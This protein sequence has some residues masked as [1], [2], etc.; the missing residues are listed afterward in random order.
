ME[1]RFVRTLILF[2]VLTLVFGVL[3][4][5]FPSI[6][7]QPKWRRGVWLDTFYWFFTQLVT[8][9]ISLGAIALAAVP[10]YLLLGRITIQNGTLSLDVN[11]ILAGYGA[12]SYLPLWV[13]GLIM[14]VVGDLIGYWT[15]RWH[16]SRQLWSIHAIHHSSEM[17]DWLTAM[18]LHPLNDIISRVCQATP[19]LLLGFSPMAVDVYVVLLTSHIAL[20]HANVSWTFGPFRYVISSPAFHRWHHTT[21]ELGAGKNFAG[22][23]PVFDLIFGTFYMPQGEQPREFGLI[24]EKIKETFLDQLL[25]PY[26]TWKRVRAWFNSNQSIAEFA[27]KEQIKASNS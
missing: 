10:F 2:V 5:F 16:H 23:F 4:R 8:Q 17:I 27:E 12:V 22:L 6:P 18:R 25:F 15:H 19:L 26:R 24:G 13:Q 21:E 20:I 3:E 11:Q 9:V 14:I 1:A 7:E